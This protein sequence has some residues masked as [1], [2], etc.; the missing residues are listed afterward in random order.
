[1]RIVMIGLALTL[2]GVAAAGPEVMLYNGDA[3]NDRGGILLGSWGSGHVSES[4]DVHYI[5][6]RVLKV[7][8]QG[9]YQGGVLTLKSPA[10]LGALA[11]EPNAYLELWVR[12]AVVVQSSARRPIVGGFGRSAGRASTAA[13]GIGV[14]RATRSLQPAARQPSPV[15]GGKASFLLQRLRI[16]LITEKGEM[17][18]EGWPLVPGSLARGGWKRVAMPLAAFKSAG[19]ERGERLLGLRIFADRADVF[20]VGQIRLI[21]DDA[22]MYL[23]IVTEP[24]QVLTGSKVKFSAEVEAGAATALLS[25][26]FDNRDGLQTDAQGG[27]VEWI[28][29]E[30]GDYVITCMASDAYGGKGQVTATAKVHVLPAGAR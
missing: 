20:Y 13:R 19:S 26:D 17:L 14:G 24:A 12:P 1:M 11:A 30:P 18:V 27:K 29:R 28:Y 4:Y 21:V 22:P 2:A 3:E 10:L 9:Y 23:K 5:G 25:W 16:C 7:L 6:P 15:S 8:S